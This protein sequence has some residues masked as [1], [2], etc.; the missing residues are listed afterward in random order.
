MVDQCSLGASW[1]LAWSHVPGLRRAPRPAL[2]AGDTS[3]SGVPRLD[4]LHPDCSQGPWEWKQEGLSPL[5]HGHQNPQEG[6]LGP[7]CSSPF[8]RSGV[9]PRMG[10]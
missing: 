10:P 3:P 7:A 1:H 8:C 9:G 4:P 6:L 5:G 2:P